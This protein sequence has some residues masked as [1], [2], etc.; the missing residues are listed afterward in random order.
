MTEQRTAQ[1]RTA[2]D[3]F[4]H[5]LDAFGETS[6]DQQDF[7]ACP[8]GRWAKELYYQRPVVGKF[9]VA[10]LIF[11][12]AFAPST[13]GLFLSRSRLPIAD[14]H[15]AMGYAFLHRVTGDSAHF[16]RMA[17]FLEVLRQTRCPGFE[18]YCWG[19]PFDWQTV[20]GTFPKGTPMI[21]TTPYCYDAFADAYE[22]DPRPEWRAVMRSIAEHA[23]R[24]LNDVELA[25]GVYAAS[26]TPLDKRR[27]VNANGYRARTLAAAAR[28]FNEKEYWRVAERNVNFVLQSQQADGS[29]LYA[30]D[31]EGKFIDN[32]HTC[33]VLKHLAR[34][35]ELTG[36]AGCH[37]AIERGA[38]YYLDHLLDSDGLPIPFA[39][40]PRLVMYRRD[41]YD[42]AE[43][44]NLA[45]LLRERMPE[46]N[47]VL[48]TV[49]ADLFARWQKPDGSFRSRQ[50]RFGW[51]NCPMHRWAQSQ[52]FRS[53][54]RL[55]WLAAD[56]GS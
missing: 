26:Y 33:F 45:L 49:L 36:H 41:L 28:D 6:Q 46:W 52:L 29:W 21:T 9:F 24:D 20:W 1:V 39:K 27:V 31:G 34:V 14:A 47:R 40:A 15:F 55:L 35:E 12:E 8:Y 32:F 23:L 4:V 18:H 56:D 3:R 17:H 48:D 16:D 13:R 50:L 2:V 54:T 25:P 22:I 44:V 37:E 5:W 10:P 51:D 19:Y 38:R 30:M 11:C 42:Y 7:L 53:L 43:C